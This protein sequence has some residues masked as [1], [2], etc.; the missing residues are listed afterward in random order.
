MA[1]TFPASPTVGQTYTSDDYTYA[2]DGVKWTS[3]KRQVTNVFDTVNHMVAHTNLG[4]GDWCKVISPLSDY[5]IDTSG[6]E[7]LE[8]GLY[9]T[10]SIRDLQANS[11][12]NLGEVLPTGTVV[13][14]TFADRFVDLLNVRDFGALGDGSTDDTTAFQLAITAAPTGAGIFVPVTGTDY[15]ISADLS[16]GI[17]FSYGAVTFTGGTSPTHTDLLA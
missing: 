7:L 16:L 8:N 12:A 6:D 17:T 10:L 2:F 14:R 4:I 1:L 5:T 11:N 13:A 9:A 15:I 3:V